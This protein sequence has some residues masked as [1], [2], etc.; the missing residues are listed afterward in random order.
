METIAASAVFR[1]A[2]FSSSSQRLSVPGSSA[3]PWVEIPWDF[4]RHYYDQSYQPATEAI[5]VQ[6]RRTLEIWPES[7]GGRAGGYTGVNRGSEG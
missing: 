5:A 4:S 2:R 6:G 7:G 1:S 3:G